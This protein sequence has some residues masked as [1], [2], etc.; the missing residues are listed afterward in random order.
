VAGGAWSDWGTVF[1]VDISGPGAAPDVNN[2]SNGADTE[3]T[4][5]S[6]VSFG[7]TS[8]LANPWDAL[9]NW[10]IELSVNSGASWSLLSDSATMP[11]EN[12]IH[13]VTTGVTVTPKALRFRYH[14]LERDNTSA[15]CEVQYDDP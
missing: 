15:W 14:D 10:R 4:E 8:G 9:D 7:A 13:T 2:N 11:A 1:F 12:E 6:L 3:P 5:Y